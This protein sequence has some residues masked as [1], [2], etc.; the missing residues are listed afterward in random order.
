MELTHKAL[1]AGR[2]S[3]FLRGELAMSTGL[4]NRLK[5]VGGL[6]VNGQAARTNH[7]VQPGDMISVILDEPRPEYPAED[8]PLRIIYEDQHILVADKPAGMLIHPSRHKN[9][10]T[11]ANAVLGHYV[12]TGQCSAFHP[13]TR[14]DR[15]TFGLVLLGKN[16]HVHQRLCD[17]HDRGLLEKT[18]H[19]LVFGTMPEESGTIDLPIGRRP[20]PSLLRYI[21]P[22]GQPSR[23]EYHTLRQGQGWSLLSLRPITGRTH[24]LRVHC[25]ALGCPILGDP[26]YGSPESLQ[27][28]AELG[29]ETQQLCAHRLVFPH[30]MTEAPMELVSSMEVWQ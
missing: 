19:G 5:W 8:V 28:S 2:L 7:M 10:G 13:A 14:L 17:L 26:Q 3:S 1:R 24:Q 4:M 27:L 23:T 15:D 18:Y 20:K 9:T 6:M 16:S 25:A 30:P 29:L 21:D 11:F 22:Q 12:R